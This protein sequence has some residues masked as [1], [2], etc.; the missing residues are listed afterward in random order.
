MGPRTEVGLTL[1]LSGSLEMGWPVLLSV[2]EEFGLTNLASVL[3]TAPWQLSCPI[4]VEQVAEGL[5]HINI[6]RY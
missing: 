1:P 6:V 2:A 5:K 4:K 3:V